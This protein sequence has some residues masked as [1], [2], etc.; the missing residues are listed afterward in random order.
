MECNH[1]LLRPGEGCAH[2][3]FKIPVIHFDEA[4][5]ALDARALE[6]EMTADHLDQK[7]GKV[8]LRST[9]L[10]HQAENFRQVAAFLR[11]L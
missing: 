6:N 11:K 9:V 8:I 7:H 3:S 1:G 2:C 10:A 4:A 5:F